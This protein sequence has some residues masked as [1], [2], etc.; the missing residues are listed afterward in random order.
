LTQLKAIVHLEAV[1]LQITEHA[2]PNFLRIV[3]AKGEHVTM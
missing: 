3:Q 2:V 1:G